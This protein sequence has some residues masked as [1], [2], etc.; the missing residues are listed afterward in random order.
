M[1][2]HNDWLNQQ[3]AVPVVGC[4][5]GV[6]H[7]TPAR[8]VSLMQ[9]T[10]LNSTFKNTPSPLYVG[11]SIHSGDIELAFAGFSTGESLLQFRW[12]NKATN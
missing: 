9:I 6:A 1:V 10:L 8:E 3:T 7:K 2:C 11:N 4:K 12:H 5:L